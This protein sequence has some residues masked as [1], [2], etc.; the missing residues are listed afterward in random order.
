MSAFAALLL[1]GALWGMTIPL[2]RIAVSTGHD[3]VGLIFWQLL[4]GTIA[5]G[6]LT[7]ARGRR[8]PLGR[9]YW[10]LFIVVALIGT[11]IP[12]SFSYRA[13]VHLPAGIMALVIAMVPMFAMPIALGLRLE[14]PRLGR[15]VGV[16]L[17]AIAV[18]MIVGPETS[19][20]A[21]VAAVWVAI[22]LIA[23]LC[24]GLEGNYL[25]W[26]GT[27]GLDPVEVLFGASLFGLILVTPFAVTGG[28]FVSLTDGL[29]AAELAVLSSGVLHAAAYA[30]YVYLVGRAGSVFAS[31]VAY[32]VTAFG[33]IWSML[34]LGERY[35]LWVW[36]A[37]GLMLAGMA[38]VQPRPADQQKPDSPAQSA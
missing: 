25:A 4:I 11:L 17:G 35:A 21:G 24:Y 34:L 30:G 5:L 16:G 14:R 32:L 31:Q 6:G 8:L 1:I 20:P 27:R 33:V 18:A 29:G 36:L 2:T 15:F 9:A 19:L 13:A 23:P 37:F 12:N 10:G 7:F 26:K 3:P 22:S 28:R 38:L